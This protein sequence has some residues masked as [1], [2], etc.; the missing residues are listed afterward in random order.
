MSRPRKPQPTCSGLLKDGSSCRTWAG[1]SGLCKFHEQAESE[2]ALEP[3]VV[4]ALELPAE[5]EEALSVSPAEIRDRLARDLGDGYSNLVRALKEAMGHAE[6]TSQLTCRKCGARG[7]YTG[8]D[9][10]TRA[11]AAAKWVDLGLGKVKEQPVKVPGD[12]ILKQIHEL[13]DEELAVWAE[14]WADDELPPAA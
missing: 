8:P 1:P 10:K 7:V 11:D 2:P 6:K 5:A 12:K 4:D 13:S 14:A 3:P 9:H